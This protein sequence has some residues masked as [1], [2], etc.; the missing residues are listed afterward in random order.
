MSHFSTFEKTDIKLWTYIIVA[1]ISVLKQKKH[2]FT[3][4]TQHFSVV[5]GLVQSHCGK[6]NVIMT[7]GGR[8]SWSKTFYNCIVT[9]TLALVV[10]MYSCG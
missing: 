3:L 5:R 9:E 6:I 2:C 7:L 10:I 4:H 1:C 8:G